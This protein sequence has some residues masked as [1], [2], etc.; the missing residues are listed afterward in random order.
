MNKSNAKTRAIVRQRIKNA[1]I[2]RMSQR[3]SRKAI[4]PSAYRNFIDAFDNY[5]KLY[6]VLDSSNEWAKNLSQYEGDE[7]MNLAEIARRVSS[8]SIDKSFV[9][10]IIN[11]L[12]QL[13]EQYE[14]ENM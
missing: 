2:E 4:D 11:T 14:K 12:S 3:S 7:Y 13:I 5:N 9:W 10:G 8:S 1:L 6:S